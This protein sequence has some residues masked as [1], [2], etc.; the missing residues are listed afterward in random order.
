MN[1]SDYSFLITVVVL[2]AVVWL[3]KRQAARRTERTQELQSQRLAAD[4]QT[5]QL[6]AISP[7]NVVRHADE[8]FYFMQPAQLWS[9]HQN[10][11]WLGGYSGGSI[12]V[13]RGLWLRSGGSRGHKVSRTVVA[14]DDDGTLHLSTKRLL[15]VG[16]RGAI[17]IPLGKIGAIV[18]YSDGFRVDQI[19]KKALV[20]ETG[21][22]QFS[23]LLGRV[24]NKDFDAHQIPLAQQSPLDAVKAAQ[25]QINQA[26]PSHK[27]EG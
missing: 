6:T 12:R 27:E 1:S 4:A 17:E 11:E 15:F 5:R 8:T 23:I 9:L 18:P 22:A 16:V 3:V 2:V 13:A 10:S 14:Q 24:I 19:N 26:L 21:D 7:P 25:A 20:F